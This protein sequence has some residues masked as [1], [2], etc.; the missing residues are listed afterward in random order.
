MQRQMLLLLE[1]SGVYVCVPF[2]QSPV[3]SYMCCFVLCN[4]YYNAICRCCCLLHFVFVFIKL[5]GS[6]DVN[7]KC[8]LESSKRSNL[9]AVI[10]ENAIITYLLSTWHVNHSMRQIQTNYC[11]LYF[12]HMWC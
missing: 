11:N 5:F 2:N 10:A 6:F 4:R 3:T 8:T 1:V 12:S 7:N 9:E